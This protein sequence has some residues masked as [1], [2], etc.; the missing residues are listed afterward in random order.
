MEIDI[1]NPTIQ[2]YLDTLMP[3][4]EPWFLEMEDIAKKMI[5]PLSDH[6]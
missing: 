1:L 6:K 5:F 3:D 2:Q 4:R